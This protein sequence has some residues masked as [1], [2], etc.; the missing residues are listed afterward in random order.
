LFKYELV[1]DHVDDAI[2][3]WLMLQFTTICL[4]CFVSRV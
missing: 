2:V 1:P 3:Y 4:I